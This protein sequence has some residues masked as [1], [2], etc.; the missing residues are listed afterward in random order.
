MSTI[1]VDIADLRF[2]E[3]PGDTVITYALGS[4]VAV[5][6]YDPVNRIGGM[7]HYMLPSSAKARDRA[8]IN[9]LMYAD[10]GIPL[11]FSGMYERGS[12][13]E[14]LVVCVVGGAQVRDSGGVFNIGRRNYVMLRKLFWKNRVV[15]AAEDVGGAISR[16]VKFE[17]RT[18]RVVV[19]RPDGELELCAG[20]ADAERSDGEYGTEARIV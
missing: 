6:V 4:C 9:P 10:T 7:I 16:T 11:L 19:K 2:S 13:K 8:A 20:H 17:V 1:V 15:I 5:M 3:E 18:G 14:D 12:N